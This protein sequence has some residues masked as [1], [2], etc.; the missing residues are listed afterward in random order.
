MKNYK[1]LFVILLLFICYNLNAQEENSTPNEQNNII[2]TNTIEEDSNISKASKALQKAA[3]DSKT[4][5][6]IVA[7]QLYYQKSYNEF[8]A[9][10]L[11]KSKKN[12]NLFLEALKS[13]D[14]DPA[15][16]FFIFDDFNEI[17]KQ[18]NS[19]YSS[20]TTISTSISKEYSIAMSAEDN[21]LVEKYISIYSSKPA[22][23]RI[24]LALERSGAYKD[25]ILKTLREM[26]LPEELL[27]LPIVES[28]YNINT[29][30]RAGAVGL[31]QIMAHRGRALGLQINY[32]ID[33]RK[34]PEKSTKAACL[35]LKQLYLM[36]ND[37]HLALAAY[38]RGEYGLIRDMR[39][40][41]AS[42]F[43]E[44]V[45]RNAIPKETQNYVPQFIAAATIAKDLESYGFAALNYDQPLK[46]DVYYTNKVIDLKIVASCANTTLEEIK[47]L[48][49][50]LQA[51]STP[52][53][54]PN[55]ALKIPYGSKDVFSEN[56]SKVND[57]N[58]SPGFVKH[59]IVKGEYLEKIAA[60]YKT[61]PKEI[62]KDNTS[63]SRRKY[64]R[65]GQ[66]LIIR[67]GRKYF[68]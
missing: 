7:A 54:Y 12:F 8:K 36:L 26:N 41:N 68:K 25:I 47:R 56:I 53:G 20:T 58:P 27:Y 40:S 64:L 32:W 29:I 2:Q 17:L 44:M 19:I 14:I 35:Y 18:L 22:K 24:K 33:E 43:S 51:W 57:L 13:A 16:Y 46:Y 60:K 28:L 4:K 30:S 23:E 50:A 3:N 31:W 5:S 11:K 63:L 15:L 55:F 65:P 48:N 52:L 6:K 66:T 62:Y 38:N 21:S 42:N 59:K 45:N 34:D 39:F 37:W 61:T 1:I 67:P 10:N 9:N 49:P